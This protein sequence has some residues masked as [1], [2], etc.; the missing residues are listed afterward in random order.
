[1]SNLKIK[2][3]TILTQIVCIFFFWNDF[4]LFQWRVDVFGG[5]RQN[6]FGDLFS[7]RTLRFWGPCSNFIS[8]KRVIKFWTGPF[9]WL[10][11]SKIVEA[12]SNCL[13]C[14]MVNSALFYLNRNNSQYNVFLDS[15]GRTT[16][17]RKTFVTIH[18][19]FLNDF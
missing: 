6:K 18:L 11:A 8:K 12:W 3:F 5:P 17:D 1:M 9:F 16:H 15:P 4:I 7:G 13:I 14:H 10:G 19:T 2:I